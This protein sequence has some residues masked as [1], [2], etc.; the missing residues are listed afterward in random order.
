MH[1]VKNTSSQEITARAQGDENAEAIVAF[2]EALSALERAQLATG[3]LYLHTYSEGLTL[4]KRGAIL[5]ALAYGGDHLEWMQE[6]EAAAQVA[7]ANAEITPEDA[8]NLEKL[9]TSPSAVETL[10]IAVQIDIRKQ[11]GSL[12]R[13]WFITHVD[14]PFSVL[15]CY[16]L[17]TARSRGIEAGRQLFAQWTEYTSAGMS[18]DD[19]AQKMMSDISQ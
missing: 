1:A 7:L 4:R 13:K 6:L 10:S 3:S 5:P 9:L 18:D 17:D 12:A 2:V 14:S 15:Q 16:I 8:G 11:A 19:A